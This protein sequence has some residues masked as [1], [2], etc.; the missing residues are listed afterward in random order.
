M[1]ILNFFDSTVV[2]SWKFGSK[3][4]RTFA[5]NTSLQFSHPFGMKDRFIAYHTITEH[6]KCLCISLRVLQILFL[7]I[8]IGKKLKSPRRAYELYESA[9]ISHSFNFSFPIFLGDSSTKLAYVLLYHF[10]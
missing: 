3:Y 7:L 1:F 6:M 9:C 4:I 5:K 8:F 2:L 10:L